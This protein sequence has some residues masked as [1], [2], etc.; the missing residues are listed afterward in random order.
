M[1]VD[2]KEII[3][4]PV[5]IIMMEF[6]AL[7]L[8]AYFSYVRSELFFLA[9][10]TASSL[11][12]FWQH[13]VS[14]NQEILPAS[15][16]ILSRLSGIFFFIMLSLSYYLFFPVFAVKIAVAYFI[17]IVIWIINR[18]LLYIKFRR[19]IILWHLSMKIAS[20]SAGVFTVVSML[21]GYPSMIFFG[22]LAIIAF[23]SVIEE[24]I[25]LRKMKSPDDAINSIFI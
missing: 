6:I 7:S 9:F 16:E 5:I 24:F 4:N 10:F 25:I 20:V 1:H 11:T 18:L 2:K 14:E 23:F 21:S 13:G 8:M 3:V 17:F 22:I 15:W 19:I 12:A